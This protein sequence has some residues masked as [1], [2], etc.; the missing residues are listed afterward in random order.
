MDYSKR[1]LARILPQSPECIAPAHTPDK[2]DPI[3]AARRCVSEFVRIALNFQQ[4]TDR[5]PTMNPTCYSFIHP[6]IGTQDTVAGYLV[7][8]STGAGEPPQ[9]LI[10]PETE[11]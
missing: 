8:H 3:V 10:P 11:F 7:E 1:K 9:L 2:P 4:K 5:R 6:L